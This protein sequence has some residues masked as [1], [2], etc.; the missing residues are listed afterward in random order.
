MAIFMLI[1]P[2]SRKSTLDGHAPYDAVLDG[3]IDS[4]RFLGQQASPG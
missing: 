4:G 2:E 3:F 1:E